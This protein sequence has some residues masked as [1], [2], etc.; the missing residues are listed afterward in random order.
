MVASLSNCFLLLNL[1]DLVQNYRHSFFV[2]RED[3]FIVLPLGTHCLVL[4]IRESFEWSCTE[5]VGD[6]DLP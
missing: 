1:V 6:Y 2:S 3:D 5:H 4:Y